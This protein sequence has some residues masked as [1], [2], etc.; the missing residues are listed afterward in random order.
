MSAYLAYSY[1]INLT[2]EERIE[3]DSK[4]KKSRNNFTK[5]FQKG[6]KLSL[7]TY[8]ILLLL[9]STAYAGDLPPHVPA[10]VCP[11]PP[12]S[13]PGMKPLNEKTKGAFVGASSTICATALQTGDYALGI[14]CAFL[15]VI[16]AIIINRPPA[17]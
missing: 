16:G 10:D 9:K 2:E 17:G 4:V 3:I 14:A 11:E 12:V 13:K 7:L 8:S 6:I 1:S 5:G 15:I